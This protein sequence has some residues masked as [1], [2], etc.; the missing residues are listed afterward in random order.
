MFYEKSSTSTCHVGF[1]FA[2]CEP[3]NTVQ[4]QQQD[5]S[6]SQRRST[7]AK[8]NSK[9]SLTQTDRGMQHLPSSLSPSL[10]PSLS[11][12]VHH[13]QPICSMM[14]IN[15]HSSQGHSYTL[16]QPFPIGGTQGA[17]SALRGLLAEWQTSVCWTALRFDHCLVACQQSHW[18]NNLTWTEESARPSY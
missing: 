9:P 15:N 13:P 18:T 3:Q 14:T 10:P 17:Q 11:G 16:S 5:S 8:H 6:H 12:C 7:G 4:L 2:S 1:C